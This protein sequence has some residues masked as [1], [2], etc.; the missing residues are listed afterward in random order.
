[1]QAMD[2]FVLGMIILQVR[3]A[4]YLL[5]QEWG[6]VNRKLGER[7]LLGIHRVGVNGV[8]WMFSQGE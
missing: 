4:P 8:L 7:D 5:G 1:M 6:G 2:V 3:N